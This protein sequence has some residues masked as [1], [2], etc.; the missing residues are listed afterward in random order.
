M[1]LWL[2]TFIKFDVAITLFSLYSARSGCYL[3]AAIYEICQRYEHYKCSYHDRPPFV[4]TRNIDSHI[5]TQVGVWILT[6]EICFTCIYMAFVSV[7]PVICGFIFAHFI[8][9]CF[10]FSVLYLVFRI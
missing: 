1:R 10:A 8:T 9:S 7:I 3:H 5:A 2:F 6:F 4:L